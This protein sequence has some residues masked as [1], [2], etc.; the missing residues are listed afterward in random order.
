MSDREEME[1]AIN[2]VLDEVERPVGK[3]EPKL[4]DTPAARQALLGLYDAIGRDS[5]GVRP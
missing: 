5:L 4:P 2:K 3:L 1:E